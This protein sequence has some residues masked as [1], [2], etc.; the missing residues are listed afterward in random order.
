MQATSLPDNYTLTIIFDGLIA[1]LDDDA[2]IMC[3]IPGMKF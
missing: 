1:S 3:L 2:V